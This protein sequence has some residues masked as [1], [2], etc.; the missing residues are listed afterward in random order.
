MVRQHRRTPAA[1]S[2]THSDAHSRADSDAH[3][4]AA[5]HART[6]RDS[7]AHIDRTRSCHGDPR[8]SADAGTDS[9]TAGRDAA[10]RCPTDTGPDRRPALDWAT[11]AAAGRAGNA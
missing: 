4:D 6:E 1:A 3:A 2:A 11:I 10:A 5:R 8:G 9:T 7:T